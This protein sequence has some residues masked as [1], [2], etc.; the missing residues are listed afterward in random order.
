MSKDKYINKNAV[1]SYFGKTGDFDLFNRKRSAF[2]ICSGSYFYLVCLV[3]SLIFTQTLK[4]PLSNILFIFLLCFP[5]VSLL[6]ILFAHSAVKVNVSLPSPTVEKLSPTYYEILLHNSSPLP[7]PFIDVYCSIPAEDTVRCIEKRLSLPLNP[8]SKYRIKNSLRFKY[9]GNYEIGVTDILVY[10]FFKL[11]CIRIKINKIDSLCVLPRRLYIE[12]VSPSTPSELSQD[13]RLPTFGAEEAEMRDVRSYKTGDPLKNIHWK[14]SAKTE[15]F[16]VRQYTPK[17]EKK[18]LLLCDV[19][20]FYSPFTAT[21]DAEVALPEYIDDMNEFCTDA[22]TEMA[23]AILLKELRNGAS[24][25]LAWFDNRSNSGYYD[26][27]FESPAEF[28]GIFTR[29]AS[30]PLCPPDRSVMQLLHEIPDNQISSIVIVT[31]NLSPET[32]SGLSDLSASSR[33]S[34]I[35]TEIRF[36]NPSRRYKN[37]EERRRYIDLVKKQ[38]SEHGYAVFEWEGDI[39]A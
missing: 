7:F 24:C 31:A 33:M 10:D 9:R 21:R 16:Q 36:F 4:S 37:K 25:R 19:S 15:E 27:S 6:Y 30:A 23:T 14:L 12:G 11:F 17:P 29:F 28:D 20:A 13:N 3:F 35:P 22:I 18:T 8:L 34:G 39:S 5:L 1:K 38:L 2:S 26:Y 32:V